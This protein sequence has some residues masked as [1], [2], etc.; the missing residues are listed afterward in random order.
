MGTA[1][2]A[3]NGG[4]C[5]V[6]CMALPAAGSGRAGRAARRTR[7]RRSGSAASWRCDPMPLPLTAA[8][9][10]VLEAGLRQRARL[11]EA[12]LADVY[13]AAID[14]GERAT[15]AGRWSS[16][17]RISCA[18][19]GAARHRRAVPAGLRRRSRARPGRAMA[20]AGRPDAGRLRRRLCA[21]MP[22]IAGPHHAGAVPQ[23]RRCGRCSP[24]S[25]RGRQTLVRAAGTVPRAPGHGRDAD[26]GRG[27]SAL[28]GARRARARSRLRA[29]RGAGSDGAGRRA[30]SQGHRRA[31]AR[32]TC[33]SGACRGDRL[34]PLQCSGAAP[35][36]VIG[37]LEAARQGAVRILN[38]PGAALVEMPALAAFMPSLCRSLLGE[39][40]L[41]ATL[42]SMWMADDGAKRTVA[43]SFRRW[44]IRPAFD[45]AAPPLPLAGLEREQ[46]IELEA[47]I[48]AAPWK[49]CRMHHGHSVGRAMPGPGGACRAADRAQI[50]SDA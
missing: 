26:R 24:S 35:E 50:V 39:P 42:P 18:L 28:A 9:F 10:A 37:L 15:A 12:I 20:R 45:G 5:S 44:A 8:E 34:D 2:C 40:L 48:A 43:A 30:V 6:P 36:G 21:R 25:R 31:A 19:A 7:R 1:E 11:L 14:P 46:R 41:L 32:S 3:H 27:R 47:A 29:G 49:L 16:P 23:Q 33:C 4:P 38:H 22:A 13:G 17:I